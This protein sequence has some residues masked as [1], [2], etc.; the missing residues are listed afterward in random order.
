ME[1]VPIFKKLIVLIFPP[2]FRLLCQPQPLY[3][4]SR[5]LLQIYNRYALCDIQ[6]HIQEHMQVHMKVHKQ[7]F[8][9][10]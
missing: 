1:E 2:L 5:H 4:H 10:L 3:Q 9:K 6:V 8:F 7:D